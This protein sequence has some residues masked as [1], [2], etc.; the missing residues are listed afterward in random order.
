MK[1]M[2]AAVA[3]KEFGRFLDTVQRE[4]VM[5][6]KK[7]RP[8]AVTISIQDWT[9][10]TKLQV[11]HGISKGLHDIEHGQFEE[12]SDTTTTTRIGPVTV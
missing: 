10:L 1:S 12:I 7:N 11:E 5:V 3:S 2:A 8:V 9:E 6:T 4:P